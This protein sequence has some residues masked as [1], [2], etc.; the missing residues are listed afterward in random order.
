MKPITVAATILSL[1]TSLAS[2]GLVIIPV[3]PDQVIP[4]DNGDCF[5]GVNTPMGCAPYVSYD[6]LGRVK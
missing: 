4:K 5:L 2:A 1:C 6:R 3:K